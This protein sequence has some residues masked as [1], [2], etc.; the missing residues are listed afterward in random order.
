[1][2][3]L[4][5][6]R[7]DFLNQDFDAMIIF[8]DIVEAD[9]AAESNERLASA[10]AEYARAQQKGRHLIV[11]RRETAEWIASLDGISERDRSTFRGISSRFTQ[12]GRIF[13]IAAFYLHIKKTGKKE[14]DIFEYHAEADFCELAEGMYLDGS[15]LI[16]E[17]I[18]DGRIYID[19][20]KWL[21][22]H[23]N[24]PNIYFDVHSGGGD[25][26]FRD[27][28]YQLAQRKICAVI[29][30]SDKRHPKG[31]VTPKR[32]AL[33]KLRNSSKFGVMELAVL[34]CREIENLIPIDAIRE[35]SCAEQRG[36]SIRRLIMI[37][38][39][40]KKKESMKECFWSFFDCKNGIDLQGVQSPDRVDEKE[41]I[42]EH[43]KVIGGIE[44]IDGF[45]DK[46]T[47]LLVENGGAIQLLKLDI[48]N[49]KKR[50][51]LLDTFSTIL[52]F[53]AA[54]PPRIT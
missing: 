39:A 30:D 1:M 12:Y 43:L 7:M 8:L 27:V 50:E 20:M 19:I 32:K 5:T 41:W 16:A 33:V 54:L 22:P 9:F 47:S 28:E 11:A 15:K 48:L 35:L 46:I 23:T 13:E 21:V 37:I 42:E 52:W 44:K 26:I 36:D 4:Q 40:D 38:D 25:S 17:D 14:I 45:G 24:V 31:N 10:V 3:R 2:E 29:I 49:K 6:G 51:Q 53:G 34:P 18:R